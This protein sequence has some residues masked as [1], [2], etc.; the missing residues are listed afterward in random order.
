MQGLQHVIGSEQSH[1]EISI[2]ARIGKMESDSR[3][4]KEGWFAANKI[5]Q[6]CSGRF[7][8]QAA[9]EAHMVQERSGID[10]YHQ[11]AAHND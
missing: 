10:A 7:L 9:C 1:H 6:I 5:G 11:G 2:S 8:D 4:L 3:G